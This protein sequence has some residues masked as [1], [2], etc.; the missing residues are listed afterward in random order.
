M[1]PPATSFPYFRRMTGRRRDG[2]GPV[3]LA[4][5]AGLSVLLSRGPGDLEIPPGWQCAAA[6]GFWAFACAAA[7]RLPLWGLVLA[8]A[9]LAWH[10][11]LLGAVWTGGPVIAAPVWGL[12]LL[13]LWKTAAAPA[14]PG[15]GRGAPFYLWILSALAAGWITAE[16]CGFNALTGWTGPLAARGNLVLGLLYAAAGVWLQ[17]R[18]RRLLWARRGPSPRAVFVVA[19]GIMAAVMASGWRLDPRG[20]AGWTADFLR[21]LD[22]FSGLIWFWLGG[23]FVLALLHPA[24]EGTR[25]FI[26]AFSLRRAVIV[27][28][29]A[30]SAATLVEWLLVR[31]S[32]GLKPIHAALAELPAAANAHAWMGIVVLVTGAGFLWQGREGVRLLP[33][34][35]AVW[36]A[37]FV[38]LLAATPAL[39]AAAFPDMRPEAAATLWPASVVLAALLPLEPGRTRAF[40]VEEE[41]EASR[42]TTPA[43]ALLLMLGLLLTVETGGR[44]SWET[45]ACPAALLGMLHLAPSR[46]FYLWWRRGRS[47]G[48]PLTVESQLWLTLAGALTA[49][50]LL[51]R[52]ANSP[53]ALA[54]GPLLWLPALLWLRWRRPRLDMAAGATAGALLAGGMLAAWMAPG[55]MLPEFPALSLLNPA[56]ARE[57]LWNGPDRFA[58]EPP[59]FTLLLLLLCAGALL[60]GL[61]FRRPPPTGEIPVALPA[62]AA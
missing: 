51:Q 58:L 34:L 40:M 27:M 7:S 52:G 14:K 17:P 50:P 4:A 48:P 49:L 19:A 21:S 61:V 47:A 9:W 13:V 44:S 29:L 46:A 15:G 32:G 56:A 26:R 36:L 60:G 62:N 8:G 33:R 57:I 24:E 20:A 22:S 38:A 3:A 23:T 31:R 28:P 11:V 12:L 10:A 45:R 41:P 59:H 42:S 30:W 53:V 18:L 55:L 25:R 2:A 16:P 43:G 39:V 1:S 35:N 37:S 6:A 54:A 5:A